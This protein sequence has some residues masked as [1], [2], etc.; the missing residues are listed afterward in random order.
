MKNPVGE[1]KTAWY[2]KL[3]GN[4]T[5]SATSVPIFR[6]D[7]NKLPSSHYILI[8]AAG[9]TKEPSD[10]YMRRVSLFI[11]I[12]SKFHGTEGINDNVVEEIDESIN[13]LII[14]TSLTDALSDGAD[15]QITIVSPEDDTYETFIDTDNSIKYHIKTI[16]WEHLCVQKN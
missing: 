16:R 7:A 1:L 10:C 2:S 11:Q 14:P 12:V 4:I 3:N 15:F 5:Y 8:R 9:S 6:E 13:Q